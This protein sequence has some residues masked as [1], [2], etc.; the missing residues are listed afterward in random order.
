[1]DRI[2]LKGTD[3]EVSRL[4]MGTM[5]FGGQ[6]DETASAAMVDACLEAGINF[7]DTANV[8]TGGKSEEYLGRILKGRRDQ[9]VLATKVR[10]QKSDDPSLLGLSRT[11][12][13]HAVEESLKRLQTDYLDLYY[14]HMPDYDVPLEESLEAMGKLVQAGKVRHVA[15]SN[16]AS[17]QMCRMHWLA[18]ADGIPKVTV[19]QPMYN[20]LSRG[21][22]AEYLPMCQD[23]GV[24]T[25]VY[26][27]LAGGL[28]TGKHKRQAPEAGGRF[29][30]NQNYVER[31]WYDTNFD[32]VEE[33]AGACAEAGRSMVSTAL[34]WLLHHTKADGVILGASRLEQLQENIAAAEEGPL[35]DDLLAACDRAWDR[36]RGVFPKYNR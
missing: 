18:E 1:M 9:V 32:A 20:I 26:N 23:L 19:T 3:L 30:T 8:Y 22:E 6:A 29:D 17:W 25:V 28:L 21:L 27:P 14:M 15:A 11:A 24:A 36:V 12:I 34:G 7:I 13:A 33:L 16:Y 2:T 35:S 5:T 4:C 10:G 31:Y